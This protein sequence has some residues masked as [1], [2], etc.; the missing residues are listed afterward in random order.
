[1]LI[2]KTACSKAERTKA[3]ADLL[4][5]FSP[6]IEK[7]TALLSGKT[8]SIWNYDTRIFLSMFLTGR[9]KTSANYLRQQQY[10]AGVLDFY[11]E[12]DIRSDVQLVFIKVVDKH[13]IY[14]GIN[15]LNPL[16]MIFR[17]RLKAWFNKIAR[18]APV[19]SSALPLLFSDISTE[20]TDADAAVELLP[21]D[22]KW[23]LSPRE[24][25]PSCS[26]TRAERYLLHLVYYRNTPIYLA[27]QIL[28]K[29]KNV[30]RQEYMLLLERLSDDFSSE[31]NP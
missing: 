5:Y 15:A 30:L 23:V 13:R 12:E 14:E 18:M 4:D 7:Y 27:A 6:Y 21:L 16:T 19:S 1:M 26:L 9:P 28:D 8:V 22:L 29:N 10:I 24:G 2:Y 17:Y 20:E 25:S 3:L 11:P 31:H